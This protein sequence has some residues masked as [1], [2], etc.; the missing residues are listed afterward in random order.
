MIPCCVAGAVTKCALR[1]Q[2][3]ICPVVWMNICKILADT[4]LHLWK[5]ASV[6]M[7]VLVKTSETEASVTSE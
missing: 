3:G 7:G 1:K 2:K 4:K 5:H 6:Q